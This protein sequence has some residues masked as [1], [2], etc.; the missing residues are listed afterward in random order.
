MALGA[1]GL[2]SYSASGWRPEVRHPSFL[3]SSKPGTVLQPGAL[4]LFRV[5]REHAGKCETNSADVRTDQSI[6][7]ESE[8]PEKTVFKSSFDFEAVDYL[9]K[10]FVPRT[11][12]LRVVRDEVY[13]YLNNLV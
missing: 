11:S 6:S 1:V 5:R 12:T 10:I 13:T 4:P 2:C 7:A 3:L 9:E 8:R